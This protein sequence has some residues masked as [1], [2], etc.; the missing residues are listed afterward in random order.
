MNPFVGEHLS[1]GWF[2]CGNNRKKRSDVADALL[3]LKTYQHLRSL[4]GGKMD[5]AF[6]Q[7]TFGRRA[8][9]R[10][11]CHLE[12]AQEFLAFSLLA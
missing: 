6:Q 7:L 1:L 11:Y 4:L 5:R 10:N 2:I 8:A 9:Q 3:V 12:I